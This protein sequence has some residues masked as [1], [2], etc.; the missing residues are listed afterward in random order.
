MLVPP[1]IA[2]FTRRVLAACLDIHAVWSID[3]APGEPWADSG[4]CRLLVFGDPSA[5]RRLRMCD[6]L[7]A[8]DIE[9]LV[10]VDGDAFAS[11]WGPT[12]LPGSLAR[13]AWRQGAV[14]EAF[15][16]ESRWV[17]PKGASR[18][19]ERVR[20]TAYLVWSGEI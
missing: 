16:D 18:C 12:T 9:V 8:P 13:W 6:A 10:V 19:V 4:Q 7:H 11:A 1:R 17:Q 14:H 15:Y 20:R 3:H 2:V 5:L